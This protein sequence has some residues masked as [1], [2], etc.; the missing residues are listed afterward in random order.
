M[1]RTP[2]EHRVAAPEMLFLLEQCGGLR[3]RESYG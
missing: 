1:R 3:K 2:K